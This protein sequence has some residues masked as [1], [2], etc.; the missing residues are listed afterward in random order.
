MTR[1]R[2]P[3]KSLRRRWGRRHGLL[4]KQCRGLFWPATELPTVRRRRLRALSTPPRPGPG[5]PGGHTGARCSQR[6]DRCSR[7]KRH[8]GHVRYSGCRHAGFRGDSFHSVFPPAI[9][10]PTRKR[11]AV[12]GRKRCRG[13]R[14]DRTCGVHGKLHRAPPSS[15][16]PGHSDI[17][18]CVSSN[19]RSASSLALQRRRA[20]LG[21][22]RWVPVG[23]PGGVRW[24]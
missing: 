20:A 24:P 9:A 18:S 7:V 22:R 4:A 3:A 8:C 10:P 2:R 17:A 15:P 14:T 13:W 1:L 12:G 23:F 16:V 19:L 21:A 11:Y 6:M 5:C